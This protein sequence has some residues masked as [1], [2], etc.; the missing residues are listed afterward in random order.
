MDST[1]EFDVLDFLLWTDM[2]V[3]L[4][5]EASAHSITR[6]LYCPLRAFCTVR[7]GRSV[8]SVTALKNFYRGE[9]K[10][11]GTANTLKT[12]LNIAS[13]FGKIVML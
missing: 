1:V 12:M 5:Y 11:Y 2:C 7:Y 3:Q 10:S 8:L 13:L 9:E 6:G 4:G